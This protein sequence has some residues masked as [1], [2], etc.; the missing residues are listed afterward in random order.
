MDWGKVLGYL[1]VLFLVYA[2]YSIFKGNSLRETW[3]EI[4]E[5]FK[6]YD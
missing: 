3:E 5:L 2:A 4:V 6:P 1:I